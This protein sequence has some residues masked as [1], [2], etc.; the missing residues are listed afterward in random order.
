MPITEGCTACI[1]SKYEQLSEDVK[2]TRIYYGGKWMKI[3][4]KDGTAEWVRAVSLV[5]KVDEEAQ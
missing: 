5:E 1:D 3:E 4:R 2:V